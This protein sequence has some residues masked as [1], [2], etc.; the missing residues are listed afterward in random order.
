MR[1]IANKLTMPD[2][3][4]ALTRE[5]LVSLLADSVDT[6]TSTLV[7]GRSGTGKSTLAVEYCRRTYRR[8]AWYDVDETD[9]DPRVFFEY[10]VEAIHRQRPGF[11]QR[12][13]AL[14]YVEAHDDMQAV[15][16][17]FV[18]E[19]L[20]QPGKPLVIVLDNLHRIYDAPWVSGFLTRLLPLL[21]WDAHVIM[22]GRGLPPA[23]LWRLRSKQ[24]LRVVEEA[25]LAF[26]PSEVR[27]LLEHYR[28]AAIRVQDAL[29]FTH[30]RAALVDAFSRDGL[31]ACEGPPGIFQRLRA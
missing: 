26:T 23:P 8:V 2:L 20:E 4:P 24:V 6:G 18:Y 25:T 10:L 16:N 27:E 3:W 7:S 19:L 30:G 15:A 31:A 5:R 22:L 1:L 29:Q 28:Q 12:P 14:G 9:A 21:P 13:L 17:L 11:G